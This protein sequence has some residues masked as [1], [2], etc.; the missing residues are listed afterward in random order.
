MIPPE[1]APAVRQLRAASEHTAERWRVYTIDAGGTPR[2]WPVADR[3]D[4]Q[5]AVSVAVGWFQLQGFEHVAIHDRA[6]GKTALALTET[7][8]PSLGTRQ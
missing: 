6:T 7:V 3:A 4:Y 5:D 8:P 2:A 1:N